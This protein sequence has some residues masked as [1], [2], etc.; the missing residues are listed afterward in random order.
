MY[1]IYSFKKVAP[2]FHPT[3]ISHFFFV[4]IFNKVFKDS[5]IQPNYWKL[6]FKTNFIIH[7]TVAKWKWLQVKLWANI[8]WLKFV[9]TLLNVNNKS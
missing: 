9:Q 4:G 1:F 8:L 3:S 6:L 7:R 5:S 2:T